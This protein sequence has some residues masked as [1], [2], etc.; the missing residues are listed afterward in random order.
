[1]VEFLVSQLLFNIRR[2]LIE[3]FSWDVFFHTTGV[4][5]Y[6]DINTSA[7]GG[8]LPSR[9]KATINQT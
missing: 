7:L 6:R 4:D 5:Y 9:H 1:M 3:P 8:Y 2:N